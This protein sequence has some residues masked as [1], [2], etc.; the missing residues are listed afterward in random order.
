MLSVYSIIPRVLL[1]LVAISLIPLTATCIAAQGDSRKL[2][3]SADGW[4]I[5]G[6]T[7]NT[8]AIVPLLR[9][10]ANPAE[11]NEKDV[12]AVGIL[13]A[14]ESGFKLYMSQEFFTAAIPVYAIDIEAPGGGFA[15]SRKMH[16]KMVYAEGRFRTEQRSLSPGYI[17][18]V[19]IRLLE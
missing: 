1:A 11:F 2:S 10:L 8:T 3:Q 16:G 6:A 18:V 7:R 17:E 9:I 14:S 15:A 4:Y 19:S 13:A 12:Q 5:E